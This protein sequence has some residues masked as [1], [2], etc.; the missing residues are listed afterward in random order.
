MIWTLLINCRNF[1]D[2]H[3]I[4]EDELDDLDMKEEVAQSV[5]CVVNAPCS[6]WS[7]RVVAIF[8]RQT[9]KVDSAFLYV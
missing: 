9:N 2:I 8:V 7:S 1:L 5:L 6:F 4:M 3:R